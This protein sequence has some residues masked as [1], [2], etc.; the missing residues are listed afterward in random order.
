VDP[1]GK[2]LLCSFVIQ[3]IFCNS[4]AKL[5]QQIGELFVVCAAISLSVAMVWWS[6][7]SIKIMKKKLTRLHGS[8]SS[9]QL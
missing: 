8:S 5:M 3:E 6:I 9:A 2:S 7:R 1:G 4:E